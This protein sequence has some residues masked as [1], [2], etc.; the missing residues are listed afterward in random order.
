VT[1]SVIQRYEV[2]VWFLEGKRTRAWLAQA[3]IATALDVSAP[4][5][6]IPRGAL[7]PLPQEVLVGEVMGECLPGERGLRRWRNARSR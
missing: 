6:Q 5:T 4:M 3:R 7:K 1:V 2:D